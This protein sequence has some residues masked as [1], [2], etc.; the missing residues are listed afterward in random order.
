MDYDNKP[1]NYYKH[2]RQEMLDFLPS[3]AKKILDVGCAEGYFGLAIKNKNDAEVWGIELMLEHA[4]QAEKKLHKVY[5]GKCEDFMESLPNNYFDVVYFNDVLE[6]MVD[7]YYVLEIIK[8]KLVNNGVVISSIPNLRYYQ[9]FKEIYFNEDFEY[10]EEG[11]LDKTHLRFFTKKSIVRM[12]EDLN[13][14]IIS[15]IGINGEKP[16]KS[17]FYKFPEYFKVKE[18]M[19]HLQYATVAMKKD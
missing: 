5:T 19:K 6:H 14:E 12:Y 15:H 17:I 3:N 1:E 13:Y 11:I 7:P 2:V 18:D 10:K 4:L 16:K 9:V 8:T